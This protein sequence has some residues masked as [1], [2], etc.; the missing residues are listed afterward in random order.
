MH[1]LLKSW[2]GSKICTPTFIVF[3]LVVPWMHVISVIISEISFPSITTLLLNCVFPSFTQEGYLYHHKTGVW[4]NW[5]MKYCMRGRDWLHTFTASFVGNYHHVTIIL[6]SQKRSLRDIMANHF[7]SYLI[8][9]SECGSRVLILG[10][11][12]NYW[13]RNPCCLSLSSYNI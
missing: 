11:C 12:Y 7:I 2:S 9:H 6:L 1:Q 3:L 5:K 13:L 8:M 10:Y 4:W